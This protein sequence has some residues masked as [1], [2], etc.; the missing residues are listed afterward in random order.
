M[1]KDVFVLVKVSTQMD[2]MGGVKVM[3]LR[4]FRVWNKII[5]AY[6]YRRRSIAK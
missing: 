4:S 1:L 2:N 5:E 6:R 3:A